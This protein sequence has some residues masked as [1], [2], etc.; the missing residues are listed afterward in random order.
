MARQVVVD[1]NLLLLLVVGSVRRDLIERHKRL[2]QF[3]PADYDTVLDVL[4][5]V[6][7]LV[8]TPNTLTETSNLLGFAGSEHAELLAGGL[9]RLVDSCI[10]VYVPSAEAT[11][12]PEFV[13]LG[14]TDAGLLEQVSRERPLLTVD[15][16]LYSAATLIDPHAALNISP[17]LANAQ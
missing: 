3:V 5:D 10:E 9:Q 17:M 4:R 11:K 15:G 12:R 2:G 16:S 1:S 6:E 8:V 13:Y 14:L 7:E